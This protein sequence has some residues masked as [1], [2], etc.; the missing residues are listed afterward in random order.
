MLGGSVLERGKDE[1]AHMDSHEQ[2]GGQ[3]ADCKP[4]DGQLHSG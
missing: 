1:S 3:E 4:S 2:D